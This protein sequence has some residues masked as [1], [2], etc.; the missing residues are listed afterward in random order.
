MIVEV[1]RRL[2]QSPYT[3]RYLWRE[4]VCVGLD[5]GE[6]WAIRGRGVLA[7]EGEP[8]DA[9]I[10]CSPEDL[11]RMLDGQAPGEVVYRLGDRELADRRKQAHAVLV[12]A[13]LGWVGPW[14]DP[15]AGDDHEALVRAALYD[16]GIGP[17]DAR[18]PLFPEGGE[19]VRLS[20]GARNTVVTEGL[21]GPCELAVDGREPDLRALRAAALF[22][23]ETGELPPR[24]LTVGGLALAS[25]VHPRFP[26]GL[27]LARR[28]VW[29]VRVTA[30]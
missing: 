23:K 25:E 29:L 12:L 5:A 17:A 14:P 24:R 28:H 15:A 11:R 27:P 13:A 19:T 10:R 20:H 26:D 8:V 4:P 30:A 1:L 7:W 6:K 2:L 16:L 22:V 18:A 9:W 21:A 3:R